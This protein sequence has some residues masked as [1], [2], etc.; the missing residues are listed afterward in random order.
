MNADKRRS[1]LRGG[2][3]RRQ[4]QAADKRRWLLFYQHLCNLRKLADELLV[5]VVCFLP[6]LICVNPC[7]S[8]AALS[9]L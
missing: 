3:S 1:E 2:R 4:K 7:L 9:Q 6:V 8:V 5:P